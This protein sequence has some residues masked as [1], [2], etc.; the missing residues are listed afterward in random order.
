MLVVRGSGIN[1]DD[2]D[3]A[4]VPV[5][6]VHVDPSDSKILSLLSPEVVTKKPGRPKGSTDQKKEK[7]SK[8]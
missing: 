5:E 7:I 1:S 2:E 8:G 6:E 4:D 3:H